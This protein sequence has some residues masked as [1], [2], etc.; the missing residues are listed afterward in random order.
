MAI[1]RALANEPTVLLADEPTGNLDS[2]TGAEVI[3][4]LRGLWK[5]DGL[6]VVLVTHDPSIADSR[7][8]LV[9]MSD[10][11]ALTGRPEESPAA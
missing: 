3:D 5:G 2:K 10:G 11:R 9:R 4:L 1:A 7:W 6:T 8:R